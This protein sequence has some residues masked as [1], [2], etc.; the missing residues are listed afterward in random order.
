MKDAVTAT[1]AKCTTVTAT[2]RRQYCK[3]SGRARSVASPLEHATGL[4]RT[5][6]RHRGGAF[7]FS[8]KTWRR[9]RSGRS[10]RATVSDADLEPPVTRQGGSRRSRNHRRRQRPAQS[11]RPRHCSALG[12]DIAIEGQSSGETLRR[13][14]EATLTPDDRATPG[15]RSQNCDRGHDRAPVVNRSRLCQRSPF[16]GQ[17]GA[18]DAQASRSFR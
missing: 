18:E 10:P 17:L 5:C 13:I 7:D 15:S 4:A 11:N 8:A 12:G 2:A 16:P 3:E 9:S 1:K 6:E 14:A